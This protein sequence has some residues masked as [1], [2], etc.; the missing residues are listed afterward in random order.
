[1]CGRQILHWGCKLH[2]TGFVTSIRVQVHKLHTKRQVHHALWEWWLRGPKI[3]GLAW[4]L[5]TTINSSRSRYDG[6]SIYVVGELNMKHFFQIGGDNG[7]YVNN[8]SSSKVT[9]L[10][11]FTRIKH[12]EKNKMV[13]QLNIQSPLWSISNLH[14][15]IHFWFV[16]HNVSIYFRFV[17]IEDVFGNFD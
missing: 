13:I 17:S 10:Q 11:R 12:F 14:F 6:A 2:S 5:I 15:W 1:M 8:I 3:P 7:R 9:N 4:F 16:N